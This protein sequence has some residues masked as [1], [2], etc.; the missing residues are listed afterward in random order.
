M[1]FAQGHKFQWKKEKLLL[2]QKDHSLGQPMTKMEDNE[3]CAQQEGRTF[4]HIS[5]IWHTR[6]LT[7]D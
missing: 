6:R 2:I 5:T 7:H 1:N 4:S 3:I